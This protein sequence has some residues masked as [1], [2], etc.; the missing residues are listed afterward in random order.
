MI[1]EKLVNLLIS[2]DYKISFAESCTGG[3]LA[4]SIVSIANASKVLDLSVVTYANEA[5]ERIIN[6]DSD[7]IKKYGVVSEEVARQMAIGIAKLSQSNVAISSSGIAGPSGGS[8]TKPVGTVCFA[9]Y[10]N[11]KVYSYKKLFSE[12]SRNKIRQDSVYFILKEA[13]YKILFEKE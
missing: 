3:L 2:K 11:G 8:E 12:K 5:K 4:S 7:T 6:V 10:L 1:S 9:I 13:Y